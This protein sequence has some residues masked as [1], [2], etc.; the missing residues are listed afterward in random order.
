MNV[1]LT[2]VS[3]SQKKMRVE[4]PESKVAEEFNKKY[5]DLAKK[6][7]IKGFRPGKVPLSIIKSYYSKAVEH[8][9][10]AHFIE[11]TFGDAL[12]ET[13]LKPLTQADVSESHF[14]EG[15][16]FTYTA[17]VDICPPFELPAYKALEIYKPAVVV[18]DDQVQA[19][20]DKLVQ[21]HAQLRAVESDRPIGDGDVA[22]VD[23]TPSIGGKVF[24]KG[25]TQD[26]MAEIGK[27]SL[28]PDFDK[29]LLAHKPGESFSFELDYPEDASTPELA[30]KRVR[31]DLTI[32]EVKEKEVPE[33]NDDFAQSL[34]SGEIDTLDALRDEFRKR[35][36]EREEH[37]ASQ[38]MREQ[39]IRKILNGVDFEISPRVVEREADRMLQNLKHQFESQGLQFDTGTL[40]SPEYRT[41]S[42]LQA[43]KDIRAKL[44]LDKIAEIEGIVLDAEEEEQIF[45]DIAAAYRM[46]PVKVKSEFGDSA[47]VEKERERKLEDKV[48]KFIENEAVLVDT[49]EEAKEPET[50]PGHEEPEQA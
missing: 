38:T 17:L 16:A 4:I 45:R 49:P 1:S 44:V 12:K 8:E 41:G 33:L 39:I 46:D 20:L 28:H 13:D 11:E 47:I 5:R 42:K 10:S 3:P 19:E 30:G 15:G 2:D 23:F 29:H 21:S 14:E 43:E 35:L 24:E 9:V 37:R 18:A 27:G 48:L 50:G 34:G 36:L 22:I 7:K 32:K 26:F 6:S 40:D 31:F 25:K